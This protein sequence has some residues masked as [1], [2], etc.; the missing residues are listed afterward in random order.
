MSQTTKRKYVSK[1]IQEDL[2]LPTSDQYIVKVLTGKGNNLHE[3]QNDQG[4]VFLVSM[5]TKVISYC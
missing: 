4:E 5:P 2:L 1:E 3:V